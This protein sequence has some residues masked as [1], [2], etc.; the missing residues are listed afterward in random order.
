MV[1]SFP[2]CLDDRGPAK[3]LSLS[4]VHAE[5]AD[6]RQFCPGFDTFSDYCGADL[7]GERDHRLAS[8]VPMARKTVDRREAL[9]RDRLGTY[10]R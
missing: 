3:E 5:F 10:A 7:F 2:I 9:L 6:G 1:P 8:Q 4:G